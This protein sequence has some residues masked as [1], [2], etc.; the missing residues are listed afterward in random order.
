MAENAIVNS[1]TSASSFI[2][3]IKSRHQTGLESIKADFLAKPNNKLLFK[4][5]TRLIDGLLTDTW[6]HS[7]ID[8]ACCLI[9]VGGY[10]R[11]ELY[12]F[13]DLDLLILLTNEA[14]E[15]GAVMK[16][17]EQMIGLFWDLGLNVGHSVR[18]ISDC[19]NEAKSDLTTQTN[20]I[21]CRLIT[22]NARLFDDY[23]QSVANHL[24]VEPFIAGKVLE[25]RQ[26]YTKY[27]DTANN[28]EPNVKESPGG[29]RDIHSVLWITRSYLIGQTLQ[30][31]GP[32]SLK[33]LFKQQ[34]SIIWHWLKDEQLITASE[35]RHLLNHQRILQTIRIFLHFVSNRR[36]DR[37]L[38]DFQTDVAKVMGFKKTAQKRASESLMR[39]YFRSVKSVQV[40]N[41]I[42]VKTLQEYTTVDAPNIQEIN[43]KFCTQNQLLQTKVANLFQKQP[44]SIFEAFL[45]LQREDVA[46]LSAAL[47]RQL[48][49]VRKVVNREF[50][51]QPENK[52]RF[53]E[54]LSQ[55]RGVSNTLRA[56]NRYGVLGA[57]IPS[58]GKIVGQMQHDLF[59][60]YTVDEH[61]LNVLSNL[62][63]FNY[64]EFAHEFPLCSKLFRAFEEQHL[65]YLGA[66]FHDIAKGRNGDHSELGKVD[67]K[68]FCQ[69]HGLT[70]E[71]TEMVA[72]LVEAHLK[73]SS[74]AQKSDLSDPN[75]VEGFAKYVKTERRL[76][77]LY[78]LTVADIRG[79]S[80][81]VWNEWKARLLE[82]LF[83][84]ARNAL[85]DKQ[86]YTEN[87]IAIRKR[88]ATES[89][90]NLGLK[91]ESF[92]TL[93]DTFGSHYFERH[94]SREAAWQSRLLTPHLHTQKPIVRS[95]LSP[96]GDGIQVMI[97]EKAQNDIFAR[98]CNFFDRMGYSIA[99]AKIFTTDHGYALNTFI[100]LLDEHEQSVS[101]EG[102]HQY[103]ETKLTEKLSEDIP[104]EEP[105]EGR[106]SRQVKHTPYPTQIAI[107]EIA[108]HYHQV[109][110]VTGDVPGLLA[111]LAKIFIENAVEVHNAKINTMGNRAEDTFIVSGK[112]NKALTTQ[113]IKSLTTAIQQGL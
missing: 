95:H 28:L 61:T 58:F 112:H 23:I 70:H 64:P 41:E 90:L 74:T 39:R 5:H 113:Q 33:E 50:I 7:E 111:K 51:Q 71:D 46:G 96:N 89:L 91:N 80:P 19:K 75:V 97:Y 106:V 36:E 42:L 8:K 78:L 68:R 99:E 60:V 20:L 1:M 35:L 77:A 110:I 32:V 18:T 101:Y 85:K 16:K 54:I 92:E 86:Q 84:A 65:L 40:M 14:A 102:L 103:I 24:Q 2:D 56:M 72:W 93:W 30:N 26:R 13:S 27:N 100:V 22:G 37:L 9:A 94:K 88:E 15:D 10:G 34:D 55:Q 108:D 105:M 87:V 53:I 48:L 73:M 107:N 6:R 79:T 43:A 49:R 4:A 98:I 62:H 104:L 76:I 45:L 81:R 52:K 11:G 17:I 63:R 3:Q 67:A 59:H 44:S 57:Y 38:F 83:M 31:N 29:L 66:I 82:N 109:D 47:L 12:P 25:Q 21:E 69:Q